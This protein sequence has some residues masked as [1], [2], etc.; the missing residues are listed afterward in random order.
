VV[1]SNLPDV[2]RTDSLQE[3]KSAAGADDFIPQLVYTIIR[4]NPPS[5]HSNISYISRFCD[6]DVLIMENLCFYTHLVFCASFIEMLQASSLKID[7]E[8]FQKYV[9]L[10]PSSH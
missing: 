10:P 6:S 2:G 4:A 1:L 7:P 5:L 3:A 9:A 8:V